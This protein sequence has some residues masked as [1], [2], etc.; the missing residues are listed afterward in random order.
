[1]IPPASLDLTH[2]IYCRQPAS[3]LSLS[4]P[5]S[6][7]FPKISGRAAVLNNRHHTPLTKWPNKT[8]LEQKNRAETDVVKR[9]LLPRIQ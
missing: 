7:Q 4:I 8:S 6:E 9:K 5:L 1:M 3:Q 2:G